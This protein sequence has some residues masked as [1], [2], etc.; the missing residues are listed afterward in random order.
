MV[1]RAAEGWCGAVVTP[2]PNG[3]NDRLSPTRGLA[4]KK[5][6]VVAKKAVKAGRGAPE[7]VHLATIRQLADLLNDSGLTEIELEQGSSRI[8]VS[9]ATTAVSYAASPPVM[10]APAGAAT[11]V[12]AP[13]AA[14]ADSAGSLKSPM[15]GTAYLAPSPGAANFVAVGDSVRQ[16]Q[17]VLIIEAMKTMNQIN[18]HISGTVKEIHIDNGQPVEFGEVLL[19]IE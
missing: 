17:T 18:A 7:G 2:A 15:V 16:G 5:G 4:G 1:L 13:A 14:K 11:A 12:A 19:V 9:K 10:S 8:R 6:I 3:H